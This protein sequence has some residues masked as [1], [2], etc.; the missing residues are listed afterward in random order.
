MSTR[1][2]RVMSAVLALLPSVPGRLCSQ[3]DTEAA[4]TLPSA[5]IQRSRPVLPD[6]SA[7]HSIN[8]YQLSAVYDRVANRTRVT[9]VPAQHYQPAFDKPTMSFAVSISY[10]GRPSAAAPDSVELDF[11]TFTPPRA[12]WPLAHP[13]SLRIILDDSVR[14]EFPAAEYQRMSVGLFDRGRSEMSSYRI[15]SPAFLQLAGSSRVTLKVGRFTIKLDQQGFEGLRVL[16]ARLSPTV[17]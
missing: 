8:D 15:P 7:D 16:A 6:A 13:H 17:Q 1:F 4:R 12:G 9:V 14:S 10:L 2:N 3:A 5:A 11:I